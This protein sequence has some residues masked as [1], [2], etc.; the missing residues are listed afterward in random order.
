ME[1]FISHQ[2]YNE[3]I[4]LDTEDETNERIKNFKIYLMNNVESGYR[5]ESS[6]LRKNYFDPGFDKSRVK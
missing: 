4:N 3:L 6:A 5:Y 2:L 1:L